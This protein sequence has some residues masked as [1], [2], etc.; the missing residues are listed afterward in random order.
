MDK[1]HANIDLR[2]SPC[3]ELGGSHRLPP[4]SIFYAW[5]HGLHPNVILS[6]DSQGGSFK[7]LKIGT[8]A[9]LEAHNY[10]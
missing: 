1:P 9:I 2:D 6:S 10:L 8:L 4:Y 7:I 3:P 5:P